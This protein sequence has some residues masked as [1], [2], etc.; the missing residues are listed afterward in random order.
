[1]KKLFAAILALGL[2]VAVSGTASAVDVKLGGSYYVVGVYDD[3]PNLKED[4][5]SRAYMYQRLRIQPVFQIAEGLTFTMRFDALDGVFDKGK[6][7]PGAL[8][9]N[10]RS[11]NDPTHDKNNFD[12]DRA[13]VTFKTKIGLFDVG[14]MSGGA[15]GT[16]WADNEEERARIKY[17]GKFGSLLVG[18]ILEKNY[19]SNGDPTGNYADAD[20]TTYYL[21]PIYFFKGGS[22]GLLYGFIND[23]SFRPTMDMG[24]KQHILYP[25]MKATF[26]PVYVEAEVNYLFGQRDFGPAAEALGARDRDVDGW[27]AYLKAQTTMGPATFGALVGWSSGQDPAKTAANGGDITVG[28]GKGADFNPAL[29]L[30]NDDL[31]TWSNGDVNTNGSANINDGYLILNAFGDYK[32]TPKFSMGAALTWAKA[33]EPQIAGQDDEYGMEFDL[34]ATYKIYDNLSYMVGAGYLW[35]GDWYQSRAA[36]NDTKA[37]DDYILMNKLTLSF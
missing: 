27:G 10:P 30:M 21:Y 1:M 29:I 6:N 22:A 2:I 15:W 28:P 24:I 33:D 17:T 34:T 3:N 5:Y 4:A 23:N 11:V 19:E 14:M 9:A 20:A 7:A 25:Y 37:D 31:A 35:T 13:Y 26:G 32:V 18:A 36:L 12:W 16:S 8:A